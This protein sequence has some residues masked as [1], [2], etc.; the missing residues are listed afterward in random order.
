VN[1]A[2]TSHPQGALQASSGAEASTLSIVLPAKNE[3]A[4]LGSFLHRLRDTYPDAEIIVVN[5]GSTDDTAAIAEAGGAK[6]VNHPFS[7]GNGAAIKAGARAAKGDIVFFMDADGQH[8]PEAI[9]AV[10]A[11][12]HEGYDMVVG[13]RDGASQASFLRHMANA[14]YNRFASYMV[15]RPIPDLTS[16]FRAVRRKPFR[17]IMHLL[18]NTFSYP[19]TS[20]MAFFRAGYVVGYVPIKVKKRMGKS[21]IRLLR[22]GGRFLIIIFKIGALYSPLRIFFPASLGFFG[23]GLLHYAYSYLSTGRFTNMT[24]LLFI[25]SMLVFLIGLVSEQITLLTYQGSQRRED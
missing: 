21:H 2:A 7:L 20:T 8:E 5:D 24:A 10:L 19:T 23:L 18:P 4:G 3:A 13:A 16:G 11:K 1:R 22:D 25:T 14:I 9:E 6:V 12:M 17:S 15:G